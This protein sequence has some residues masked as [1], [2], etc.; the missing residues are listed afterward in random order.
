MKKDWVVEEEHKINELQLMFADNDDVSLR[1]E[2]HSKFGA[3]FC[4][5]LALLSVW[6]LCTLEGSLVDSFPFKFYPSPR[7][8]S[9]FFFFNLFAKRRTRVAKRRERKTSFFFL[10]APRLV[11][12][13]LRGSLVALSCGEKSRKISGTRVFKF[14]SAPQILLA[15]MSSS[16]INLFPVIDHRFCHPLDSPI[17][18]L[19]FLL[20]PRRLHLHCF[21]FLHA[22]LS[23]AYISAHKVKVKNKKL[24]SR[25]L[26][27]YS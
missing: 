22:E 17:L 9:W 27:T 14:R 11:S 21:C 24:V 16:G 8:I 12:S 1:L 2:E 18:Y 3:K 26:Y 20:V 23:L 15:L 19:S 5:I 13:P 4:Y 7:G 25:I 10:A 6:D